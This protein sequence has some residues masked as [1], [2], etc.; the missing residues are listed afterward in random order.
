MS[1]TTAQIMFCVF[2]LAFIINS[3]MFTAHLVNLLDKDFEG[4]KRFKSELSLFGMAIFGSTALVG[5][6]ISTA[7]ILEKGMI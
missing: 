6:F 1:S 3:G 5:L 4:P 7:S 2:A